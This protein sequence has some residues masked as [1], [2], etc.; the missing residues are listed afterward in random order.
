MLESRHESR[1]S[2]EYL[3]VDCVRQRPEAKVPGSS[4]VV[5]PQKTPRHRN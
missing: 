2:L 3:T 4:Q 1:T 5:E